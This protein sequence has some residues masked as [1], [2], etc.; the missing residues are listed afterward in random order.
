MRWCLRAAGHVYTRPTWTRTRT[1]T[2][3]PGY[4]E[5]PQSGAERMYLGFARDTCNFQIPPDL[6]VKTQAV[7]I[8]EVIL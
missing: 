7:D 1:A 2:E 6:V 8:V 4:V 3:Q 5:T